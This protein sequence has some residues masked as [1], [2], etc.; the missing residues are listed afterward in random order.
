MVKLSLVILL[1]CERQNTAMV[2]QYGLWIFFCSILSVHVTYFA[3]PFMIEA[4]HTIANSVNWFIVTSLLSISVALVGMTFCIRYLF[5][6][7][8]ARDKNVEGIR[9]IL[10]L[11]SCWLLSVLVAANGTTVFFLYQ[12]PML[13][14]PFTLMGLYILWYNSPVRLPSQLAA[15][16]IKENNQ[17]RRHN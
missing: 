3:M 7:R 5:L 10:T 16:K 2:K 8:K 9:V 14:I 11:G 15:I 6:T 17:Q 13:S 1:M 12:T 4:N